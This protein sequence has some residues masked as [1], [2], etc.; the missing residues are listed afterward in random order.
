MSTIDWER[1]WRVVSEQFLLGRDSLHGPSHWRR[2]ETNGLLLATRTGAD[3]TV[4]QLFAV[5]HDS[6]REN[7]GSDLEHG[8]RGAGL[9]RKMRGKYFELG[10]SAFEKLT[11]AC[12]WHT[13][14]RHHRDPT[15]GTCYDADRLDLGRVMIIPSPDFMSTEFGQEIARAGSI[16]PFLKN[17]KRKS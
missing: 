17:A 10:D 3:V 14:Q 5:F 1:L 12:S 2:V 13:R 6:R 8:E 7:E 4:V 15:I 11:Y 9:A 16:Q